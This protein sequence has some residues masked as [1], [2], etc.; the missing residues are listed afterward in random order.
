MS[1]TVTLLGMGGFGKTT[2][3]KALCHQPII[4]KHFLDGFLWIKLG[5]HPPNP[6]MKLN[7]LYDQLTNVKFQGNFSSADKLQC[8]VTNN[9]NRLL[10]IIDDV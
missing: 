4:K 2:M 8:Y 1:P 6:E 3:A 10:V 7:Q 5:Q 9:L